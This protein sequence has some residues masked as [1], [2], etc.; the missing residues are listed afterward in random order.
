MLGVAYEFAKEVMTP[1]TGDD[2]QVVL[3][4][5]TSAGRQGTMPDLI[6][7]HSFQ[8]EV[9]YLSQRVQQLHERGTPWNEIAIIYR[10]K[11]L[12]VENPVRNLLKLILNIEQLYL[13]LHLR[14]IIWHF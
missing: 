10:V 3:V 8:H 6:K 13:N 14:K 7:L 12:I 9:E 1:T 11:L 5:P 4:Q 2:D